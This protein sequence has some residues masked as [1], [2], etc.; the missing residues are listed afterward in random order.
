MFSYTPRDPGIILLPAPGGKPPEPPP[1]TPYCCCGDD[2]K[3]GGVDPTLTYPNP[4]STS[5]AVE[6][7]YIDS[8]VSVLLD[9]TVLL[10]LVSPS[11]FK[12]AKLAF[13]LTLITSTLAF[14]EP[15]NIGPEDP[16]PPLLFFKI[17]FSGT[18]GCARGG[19]T[20]PADEDEDD[21]LE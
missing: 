1:P 19:E 21:C 12:F 18:A 13:G 7:E 2:D 15:T 5:A 4:T 6:V 10:L 8:D 14:E 9:P 17:D 3:G 11:S 16:P 20:D